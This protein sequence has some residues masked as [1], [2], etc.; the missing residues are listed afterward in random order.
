MKNGKRTK[1]GIIKEIGIG[2]HLNC[3]VLN[4]EIDRGRDWGKGGNTRYER[5]IYSI[6]FPKKLSRFIE[7][8][9]RLTCYLEKEQER[10]LQGPSN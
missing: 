5:L 4:L 3:S 9:K 1:E 8:L 7:M 6:E 2:L 10:I